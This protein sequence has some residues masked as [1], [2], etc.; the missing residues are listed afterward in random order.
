MK[1]GVTFIIF[2]S[3]TL[4]LN[5]QKDSLT[6]ASH[7]VQKTSSSENQTLN[8]SIYP[9]PV[10]ENRFTIKSD[11]GISFVKVTNI[12]GQDI[13]RSRLSNG[14]TTTNIILENPNRGIYLVT[15]IS[16]DNI[17]VVKKI[18]IEPPE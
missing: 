17:R 1:K 14:E 12:L 2:I 6:I 11:K 18:M 7:Y 9:I 4:A 10:R 15:I 5:A 13:F 3:L 8:V 16:D